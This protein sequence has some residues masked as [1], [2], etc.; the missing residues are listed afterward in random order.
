M[1]DWMNQSRSRTEFTFPVE[2]DRNIFFDMYLNKVSFDRFTELCCEVDDFFRHLFSRYGIYGT[3]V[4]L[5]SQDKVYKF[6]IVKGREFILWT[7]DD[8]S[9]DEYDIS[10]LD[11]PDADFC[12]WIVDVLNKYSKG[13]VKCSDCGKWIRKDEVAG[14]FFA[15]RYCKDCWDREWKEVAERETYD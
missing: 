6:M 7:E 14:G 2:K 9:V 11:Y 13:F 5:K 4:R 3:S 12:D 8:V 1:I 10:K 15:G